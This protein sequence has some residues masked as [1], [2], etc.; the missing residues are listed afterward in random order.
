V[1]QT[2]LAHLSAHDRGVTL[3]DGL[4]ETMHVRGGVAFRLARHL[5]RLRRGLAALEIPSPA[6]L[7]EWL[8]VALR[9]DTLRSL[10]PGD[11]SFRVTVTRGVGPAGV[12]PPVTA[13]PTAIVTLGPMPV[14]PASMY[15]RGLAAHVASG[16][17]NERA[18]TAGLKT[19]AY[20]DAVVGLLEARRVGADEAIFLDTEGHCSEA[21]ASNIFVWTGSALMTPPLSCGAL[22]GITREAV[23]ELAR[24]LDLPAMERSFGLEELRTASEVFLTSSLRRIVPVVRVGHDAVGRGSPGPV[25]RR[26]IEAYAALVDREC[27]S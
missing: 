17:R 10:P 9:P 4:F 24:G 21:T 18:M 5:E 23:L 22:A 15:D 1:R 16:R 8:S 11:A 13:R 3:A 25:A 20:T 14:F 6:A 7:D 19:L 12:G 26:L 2:S 27:G